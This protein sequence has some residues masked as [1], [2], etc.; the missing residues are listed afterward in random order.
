MVVR[1]PRGPRHGGLRDLGTVGVGGDA[2]PDSVFV[3]VRR[4]GL[5]L[6]VHDSKEFDGRW[7]CEDEILLLGDCLLFNLKFLDPLKVQVGI[8]NGRVPAPDEAEL[9]L[10]GKQDERVKPHGHVLGSE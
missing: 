4:F 5:R 6:V 7:P 9:I 3:G 2:Y 8:S 10:F 1:S